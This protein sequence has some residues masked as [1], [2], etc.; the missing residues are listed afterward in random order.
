MKRRI[1]D[2]VE[3]FP[4]LAVVVFSGGEAFLLKDDLFEAIRFASDLGKSTRVVTNGFWGRAG[5]RA[6]EC[7]RRLREAGISEINISTGVDHAKF[8]PVESVVHAA[9]AL[10]DEAIRTLITVEADGSQNQIHA[11]LASDPVLR[12][13]IEC[14]LVSLQVNSWMPFHEDAPSRGHDIQA[15]LPELVSGC[16]QIFETVVVTPH[17]NLSACCGLTLEHIPEMRLGSLS[18]PDVQMKKLYE[19]QRGDFLKYW[20][21]VDGP[22][23]IIQRVM[24]VADSEEIL[25]GVVHKCQ[26][27]A[28]LHQSERVR[29]A[30]AAR[31]KEFVEEVLGRFSLQQAMADVSCWDRRVSQ[32]E[33]MV[34][35]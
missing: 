19:R 18:A 11:R 5:A 3:A 27:C 25:R 24:G 1:Q 33:E 21:R 14:G 29:A 2:A 34:G 15:M 26:A 28:I 6:R 7:A 13:A 30:L 10:A 20:I 16:G 22:Y 12:N 23:T 17:D 31:Y 8:V 32:D 9:S 35:S 4:S